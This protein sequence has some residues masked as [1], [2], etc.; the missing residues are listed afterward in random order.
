MFLK[1]REL[2][3]FLS[4]TEGMRVADFGAGAGTYTTLLSSKVGHSG[5]VYAFDVAE[6]CVECLGRLCVQ[7]GMKNVFPLCTDLN[8]KIPLKD[9]LLSASIIVN[10]LHAIQDRSRF[11]AEVYRVTKPGGRVLVADWIASFK[12]VGPPEECVVTP[13][14]AERLLRASGFSLEKTLPAGSHHFA[15]IAKK[16]V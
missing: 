11:L 14:E 6:G 2:V 12:N 4:C 15:F 9:N 13:G 7:S 1:P 5:A 16:D 3:G 10:T 8:T